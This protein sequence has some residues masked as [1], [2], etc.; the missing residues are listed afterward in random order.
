MSAKGKNCNSWS[1]SKRSTTT[2]TKNAPKKS[3]TKKKHWTEQMRI[4]FFCM[5]NE[6]EFGVRWYYYS[7]CC[8][9]WIGMK[10][11]HLYTQIP[12]PAIEFICF[13]VELSCW[14]MKAAVTPIVKPFK[15]FCVC[16]LTKAYTELMGAFMLERR[17]ESVFY[18]CLQ[19]HVKYEYEIYTWNI[20]EY[21]YEMFCCCKTCVFVW[22]DTHTQ[23]PCANLWSTLLV[24][25]LFF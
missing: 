9:C 4:N 19:F 3:K 16:V 25:W 7:C 23:M 15:T 1:N 24:V 20:M 10:H 8:C 6:F 2:T 11:R 18:M 13:V 21:K 12:L 22:C 14:Y 5:K 17:R